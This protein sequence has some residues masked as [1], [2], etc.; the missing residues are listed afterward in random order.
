[1]QA[2]NANGTGIG[3]SATV[4]VAA[5][6]PIYSGG[7]YEGIY[8]S[9][10][11]YYLAIQQHGTVVIATMYFTADGNY[12]FTSPDGHVLAVPQLDLFDL[13][14][15]SIS[16]ANATMTGT[17]FHRACNVGY[18]FSFSDNGNITVTKTAVSNTAVATQAGIS[19]SA[20][21]MPIGSVKVV[22]KILF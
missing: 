9:A 10:P 7:L 13:Y 2:S 12:S 1:M 3:A 21:T 19:C 5:T 15:G 8:Q 20:I 14:H 4:T 16:G 18:D 17:E 11:G 6:P 22:P